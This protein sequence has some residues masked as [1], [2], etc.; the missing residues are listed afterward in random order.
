MIRVRAL[1]AILTL[2][3]SAAA[4]PKAA[5]KPPPTPAAAPRGPTARVQR[6]ASPA[7]AEYV[8]RWH[9]PTPGK[10]PPIDAG[11]R[12][13]LALVALN[14]G[15]RLEIAAAADKGG[16]AAADLDRAAHL[17]REPSTGNEHPI[18]PRLLDLAYRLQ[19]HFKAHEVRVVSA[20]RTP[21]GGGS[22][23]GRGRALDLVVPGATDEEVAKFARELGYVGV[24]VYPT[25]GFV[26]LDVRDRSY[27]WVDASGP[28]RRNRERGV[29]ADLA[30]KSDEL[31]GGRGER[32][33][34]PVTLGKDVDAALV[35]RPGAPA[36][37]A[38]PADEDEDHEAIGGATSGG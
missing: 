27:F 38:G 15:E 4:Q 36:A 9:A 7:Y 34:P 12:P 20:Y 8:R 35:A 28:G 33:S 21:H 14:L 25:S 17:L 11:G 13:M 2:A 30:R 31:A 16:F 10:S 29:L 23:H 5:A 19:A 32:P 6:A 18:E 37:P 26:H 22:N 1:L 24:G 3:A